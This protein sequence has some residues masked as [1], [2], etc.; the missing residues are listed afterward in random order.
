MV[1]KQEH[2]ESLLPKF[3]DPLILRCFG[4][5]MIGDNL[6]NSDNQTL[7]SLKASRSQQLD[8][9]ALTEQAGSPGAWRADLDNKIKEIDS[10]KTSEAWTAHEHWWK[11]FWNR[12]WINV[13]GAPD[14]EKVTR[15]YAMQRFMTACAGRGAQ[16]IKFN[17]SAFTVGHDLPPGTV[18]TGPNHDPDYRA[19]GA[20]FWNHDTRLFY[21]TLISDGEYDLLEP[22]FDM[23]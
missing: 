6:V 8:I 15:G 17:E 11:E 9:Y 10:V 5:T 12:S 18:P 23:Y 13:T 19:W 20:C 22:W 16:P 1:F 14:T 7:K 21:Y 2:L 4:I 3:P